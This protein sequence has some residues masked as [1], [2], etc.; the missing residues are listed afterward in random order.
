MASVKAH[1]NNKL[2]QQLA[3]VVTGP[4]DVSVDDAAGVSRGKPPAVNY[5]ALST[6]PPLDPLEGLEEDPEEHDDEDA[7]EAGDGVHRN[8]FDSHASGDGP[9]IRRVSRA[10]FGEVPSVFSIENLVWYSEDGIL[11]DE[12]DEPVR[13]PIPLIGAD[14]PTFGYL[15]DDPFTCLV[16]NEEMDLCLEITLNEGSYAHVVLGYGDPKPRQ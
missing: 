7:E 14:K 16:V 2:K 15:E 1:Y 9:K 11:C 6:R 10:E 8:V 3:D 4:G 13:N 12:K 5:A